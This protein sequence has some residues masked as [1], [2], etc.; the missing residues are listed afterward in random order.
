MINFNRFEL[1]NGLRVLVHEDVSTPLAAVNI[2]YDVGSRDEHPGKTGF[3]HLFEHLM[4]G[5]SIHI[6]DFDAEMQK[7]AG[8]NNAFTSNDIT[9][10]YCTLP[11]ENLETVFWL[12]SD[13]MLEL[14][15][16]ERSLEVQR[17]VV[18]EEFRQR[19]LNQPYGDVWLLLRPEAYQVHPY[20]WPTIGKNIEHIRQATLDDVRTFFYRHYAPNNAVMVI[21][22]NVKTEKVKQLAEKWFAPI[23]RRE[24]PIRNLPQEPKQTEARILSVV[25]DVPAEAIYKVFHMDG[26]Y[27]QGFYY[28]DV[29]SDVL[30]S[31]KSARLYQRLLKDRQLFSEINAYVSGDADPGLFVVYGKPMP[32]ISLE[33][34]DAAICEEL[35]ILSVERLPENELQKQK[36]KFESTFI[37]NHTS[38]LNKAI[39]LCRH[40][41]ID[42]ATNL[43]REIEIYQ[44]ITADALCDTAASI[45]NPVNSTTLYYRRQT[46]E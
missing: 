3:A 45:F 17:Q 23:E 6:P 22:G 41:L 14:D 21:S 40:E 33:T 34:A 1:S 39:H 44:S 8:E 16:S 28:A 42:D 31:G 2:M 13:R 24:V 29:L 37:L 20:R 10:Y 43:N 30:A 9:N 19:Y 12:E 27:S 26:L 18:I 5:G 32:G 25:R 7:V 35:N 11:A 36:N 15:F 46:D 4:F 38:I